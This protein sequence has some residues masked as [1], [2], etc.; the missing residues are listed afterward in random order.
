MK[1]RR[2]KGGGTGEGAGEAEA[3][4]RREAQHAR[5]EEGDEDEEGQVG[6]EGLCWALVNSVRAALLARKPNKTDAIAP[7]LEALSATKHA[8]RSMDTGWIAC[9]GWA[10]RTMADV[11]YEPSR[12]HLGLVPG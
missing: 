1:R 9:V 11:R 12:S 5:E 8:P 4:R 2:R 6:G 3:T 10:A 7:L